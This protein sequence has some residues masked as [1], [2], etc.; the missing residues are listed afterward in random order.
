[1]AGTDV[2]YHTSSPW[3][4]TSGPIHRVQ[5]PGPYIRS[6]TSSPGLR[7]VHQVPYIESRSQVR[8]SGPIHRVQVPGPYIRSHTSGLDMGP[9]IVPVHR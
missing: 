4:D 5:V 9:Y 6:H 8:T 2:L 7:S 3:S 1:M